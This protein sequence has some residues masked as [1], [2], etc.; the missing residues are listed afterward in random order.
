MFDSPLNFLDDKMMIAGQRYLGEQ[1]ILIYCQLAWI[2]NACGGRV[3]GWWSDYQYQ[4]LIDFQQHWQLAGAFE[5]QIGQS[6]L[7]SAS[8]LWQQQ[9]EVMSMTPYQTPHIAGPHQRVGSHLQYDHSMSSSEQH[10]GYKG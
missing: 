6:I 2:P 4:F 8:A 5:G 9:A 1:N 7:W 3:S 10:S